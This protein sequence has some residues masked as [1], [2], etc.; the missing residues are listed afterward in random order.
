MIQ[1]DSREK[2]KAI[3]KIEKYFVDNNID[4]VSSK[5][6]VGDYMN[7]DNPKV[8]VDRK[9]NLSELTSNVIQQRFKNELK[10]A[11]KCGI[12][13][14][15]LCEHSPEITCLEDIPKWTNPRVTNYKLNLKRNLGLGRTSKLTHWEL[16]HLA[17]A[18][19]KIVARPPI[20][21]VQLMKSL[22]TITNN[23][24]DY[25]CSIQF[26]SKKDTGKRILEILGVE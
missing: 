9:Q 6:V 23:K 17:K 14:V 22:Y 1:I 20:D 18:R 4:Y 24:E 21:S 10:L 25:D 7:L 5:L 16:Y 11:K 13:L 19:H 15:I 12:H 26:C 3:A 2:P 8:V